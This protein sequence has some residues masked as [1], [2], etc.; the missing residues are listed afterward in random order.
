MRPAPE[1]LPPFREVNHRIPLIDEKKI[2]RYHLPWCANTIKGDLMAKINRY[3]KAGWWRPATV[4]QAAPLLCVAKK[5]GKL[6]TVVDAQQ[7]NDNTVHDLTPFPFQDQ[8]RMD[9]ARARYRSKIDL[10]DAYEQV[11][12]VTEDIW[13]TA[14]AT[15]FG[16]FVSEVMQ[17]GDTNA[18]STFQRFMT[19][20]FRDFIGQFVHVY[21]DDIFVYSDMLEEHE[22]HLAQVFEVL[23]KAKLFLSRSKCD[24]YSKDLDCLGH[25]IDD[26]GL[27]AD[28][29]KMSRIRNWQTPRS[30]HEVQ[31]FLGLVNYLAH[32]MPDVT[33]YTSPLSAMVHNDQPFVWRALHDKFFEA[34]KVLAC[35]VPILRPIDR[36]LPEPIW[37]ICDASI[38]GIGALYGQGADWQTC[39]P[40]GFLSKKFS[41]AQKAYH[42]YEQEALA[43]MEGLLK[44]EDKLLGRHIHVVTDHKALEFLQGIER[45]SR[46]QIRWYEYLARFKYDIT[47]VPGKLNKVADCLSCY[48]ENNNHHDKIPDYDMVNADA[49]LDPEGDD[50]PQDSKFTSK[51]WRELHRLM[52]VKLLM[53]T[54]FHPQTD[55]L[56][57]RTIRSITQILRTMVS[58]DQLDWYEKLPLAEFTLNSAMSSTTGFAPFELNYGYLPRSMSG[59]QMDTPFH[60][61]REFAQRALTNLE[62]AHNAIIDSRVSQAFQ[63]NKHC[64]AEPEFEVGDLVYLSTKNL[65]VPKGR[66]RK[67]V[68]KFIGPYK[69][70]E[71]FP[72]TS[73]Y[74]L[75]LPPELKDRH[76]HPHFHVLLL[77]KHEA[78][79]DAL[80]PRREARA[81]Y[82]FG[83]DNSAEW[84]VDEIVGHE[85]AG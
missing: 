72:N 32:F 3:V 57:E 39:Q 34:I 23:R 11:C 54:S 56:S 33:A 42:T 60:R 25:R 17:Q 79:D 65:S 6:R 63:A 10:S 30:Y 69:V 70:I 29:D 27:H 26:R 64:Q 83:V 75:D 16:T 67:L 41:S 84:L 44:W 38:Y 1:E 78:N 21:L 48:H 53:S 82:D 51:F 77:R 59:I 66:A 47:Y 37:L 76:I 24:L 40:A 52:G 9:V 62:M 5:N 8:I 14:F 13:K 71:S 81:F 31:R 80:F 46:H 4:T 50:L 20:I 49:R 68:P 36:R 85:W 19:T 28:T 61:V 35:K 43:I 15:P 22:Q 12:I 7:R 73:N 74:V 55:G 2:Y 58:P 45:P 18:L